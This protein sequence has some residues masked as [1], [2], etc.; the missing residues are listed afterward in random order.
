MK[1]ALLIVNIVLVI[2]VGTLFFLYFSKTNP[3]KIGASVVSGS[4]EEHSNDNF[5]IAYFEMDSI[6]NNY[7][8][9]QEIRTMFKEKER[10]LNDE[11]D[12]IKNRY[13]QLWEESSQMQSNLSEED[14]NK[15]K[16][17]LDQ[18][19]ENYKNRQQVVGQELQG[20]AFRYRFEIHKQIKDFLKEYSKV[21]GYSYIFVN[22]GTEGQDFMFYKDTGNDVTAD[23]L[24]NLNE[25]YKAKKKK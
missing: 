7:L 19:A 21:N 10:K 17:A 16:I 20:E 23:L 1:N 12:N 6:E 22:G 13:N 5:K 24:K 15:R 11:L 9:A 14:K 4:A 25:S 18:M 2:A 8:Y 3:V